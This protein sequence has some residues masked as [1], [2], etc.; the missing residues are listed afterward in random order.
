MSPPRVSIVIPAYNAE[1]TIEQA[2]CSCIEQSFDDREIIVVDDGSADETAKI[3]GAFIHLPQ[4]RLYSLGRNVGVVGA[5]K[6]G[7]ER[8]RGELIARM[9]ADDWCEPERIA[10]QVAALDENAQWAGC[11]CLVRLESALGDGMQ[12]YVDWVNGLR[13]PQHVMRERFIESP[14]IQPSVMFRRR[15]YD[16]V[17]GYRDAPW[18]EDYDLWLRM[19]D[20]GAEIGTVPETLLHWRDRADCLTRTDT[21]YG[22]EAFLRAK[23]HFLAKLPMVKESGVEI[24]AAGPI[25]KKIARYLRAEGIVVHAFYDVH[26][27][28]VGNVIDGVPVVAIDELTPDGPV[29]LGAAGVPDAREKV[30]S[31]ALRAGRLEGRDFYCIC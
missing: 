28:R 9:D 20:V 1:A 2:L 31:W 22:Q 6:V 30:R 13:Q 18:G 27:R 17:G 19:L 25:G 23:A 11:K 5:L 10:K 3:V 15:A 14:V 4:V 24:G 12:R 7:M 8:A 16:A 21:R 26:P 29:L